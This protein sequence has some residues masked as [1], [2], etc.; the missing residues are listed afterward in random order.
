M[1]KRRGK[2]HMGMSKHRKVGTPNVSD[3]VKKATAKFFNEEN[4]RKRRVKQEMFG[5]VRE[6][7]QAAERAAH[8]K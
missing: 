4:S 1:T 5:T 8:K 2:P 6:S 7:I 3:H